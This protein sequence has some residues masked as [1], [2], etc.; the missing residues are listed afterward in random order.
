LAVGWDKAGGAFGGFDY[1][2]ALVGGIRGLERF[3]ACSAVLVVV[4]DIVRIF[5]LV[6]AFGAPI[7]VVVVAF[8]GH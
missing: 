4:V 1:G 2:A 7:K 3:V 5:A 6:V 8:L